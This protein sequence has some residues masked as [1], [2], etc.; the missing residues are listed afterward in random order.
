MPVTITLKTIPIGSQFVSAIADDDPADKND[1]KVRILTSATASGLT[2]D[3]I[4][5]SSGSIVVSLTGENS[6]WEATVRP[7]TTAG[8]V[9]FTVDADAFDEGNTETSQDIRV[10]TSFPDDDAETPTELFETT[11]TFTAIAVTPT[12]ILLGRR[13]NQIAFGVTEFQ[14]DGTEIRSLTAGGLNDL[15]TDPGVWGLDYINGDVLV[16]TEESSADVTRV[17]RYDGDLNLLFARGTSYAAVVHTRFGYTAVSGSTFNVLPYGSTLE[18]DGVE[19][20]VDAPNYNRLA[21]QND[22]LYLMSDSRMGL[23][24]IQDADTIEF[25]KALNINH[26]VGMPTDPI[27]VYD[28]SAYRDSLYFF[29]ARAHDRAVYTLD[30]RPYRPLAKNTKT[31]I[32]VQFANEGST[33]P[34]TQFCPDAHTIIFG[35]EFDKPDYLSINADNELEITSDAVTETTPILIKLTGINYIDSVE[36]EFYLVIQQATAPVWRDVDSL[37]MRADSTYDLFQIVDAESIA[38]ETG[39]TQP[40]GSSIANGIF[41]IGTTAGTAYFRATK[42]SLTTDKAIAIDVIQD[43]DPDN[44]SDIARYKIEIGGIDVSSDYNKNAPLQVTKSLD[45]VELT[46]YRAHSVTLS[47]K[48]TGEKYTPDLAGNFWETNNLNPGGY[49]E[50]IKVYRESWVNAAWV[51]SL[52]FIGIIQGQVERI[53]AVQVNITANDISVELERSFISDFGTLEKWDTLRQQSDEATFEG[54]YVP[55]AS[56]SPIQP[57]SGKA[58]SDRTAVTLRRLQIPTQGPP[59]SNTGYLTASDFRTSGGFLENRPV[60]NFKTLPRSEDVTFLLNQLAVTESVYNTD[61]Q[62]PEVVLDDPTLFNR[63]SVP[64]SVEKTRITRLPVDWVYD[65]TNDRVLILLSNPEGHVSDQLVQY[66]LNSD[67]F[68]TLYEFDKD[69]KVHRIERRNS[70]NYYI[71]TSTP[72]PQD[73]S[74]AT[75]PRHADGSGYAFDSRA[76]GSVI[77]VHH[78]N[79]STGTLTEHIAEDNAR[80]PQLGIHYH[81]GFE[82]DLYIDEFE[83]IR[84]DDRGTF[85]WH[86]GNLYYRY[87]TPSEFGVARVNASGTTSEMID[88]TTLNYQNHLNF[89]FDITSGGDIYFVYATGDAETSTLTLKRRTSG[90]TEST[91]FSETRAIGDFND[92]GLDWGAFLG[93]YEALFYNSN[94]YILAPIQ[95]VDF[96]DET[97]SIIN[98]DVDIEQLTAEKTGERN[99]TTS[100]NLNPTNLTLTPGDDIPLRI[101]FDG[102]VSG[103]TEDDL[104]V[105]GGT[106][107]SF[108]ISSDMI[109]VTIHPDSQ[110]HHKNIIIDVAEDAVDQTN[111]AWRIT[112]DFETTRSRTKAAGMAL[113]RCNV[114]DSNPSLTVIEHWEYATRGGCNLIIHD[115]AVHYME[116]PPALTHY[117]PINPDLDD[118]WQDADETETMG[119]NILPDPLGALKRVESDGSLTELGNLWY[120]DRPYSIAGTRPLSFD[121]ELHFTM[122]YGNPDAVLRYNS[123]AS[124]ADNFVHLVF[125]NTLKYIPPAFQP[126]GTVYSK[127]SELAR[128]VGATV[129][130][131]GKIISVV[132]RRSFRAEVDGATGTGTGDLD[133]DG[134]NKPFPS[135]GYLRI[136]DEFIGYTGISSGAFTGITRG[137]L[138]TEAV[139]HVDTAGILYVNALFS[140]RD[141]LEITPSTDTTRHHNIVRDSNN[142]FEVTADDTNIA[143]YRKQPYTLDLGL[144]RNEVAWI[145]TIYEEYLSEL[146]TLG[147]L[148]DLKLRARKQSY[149]LDLGQWIG[150]RFSDLTYVVRIE[151]ISDTANVIEIKGRSVETEL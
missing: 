33:I 63:G 107:E 96:G 131:D 36:F 129:S 138:G 98:P 69:I 88:Q 136:G 11:E 149:A 123:L 109:D 28:L 120:D 16:Q 17:R 102:T 93:A 145:E 121:G 140:E 56:L 80:P 38:F 122:G 32:P 35:L 85:K 110:T 103:A 24:E 113:Y 134:Q 1:F 67:S 104:T 70:T 126:T 47:L 26:R 139:D 91:I 111:E 21:H 97:Q 133:F 49:Q 79:A 82:N 54:V 77:R 46:R 74:A 151:M 89:A 13:I 23:A 147:K 5:L 50:E 57:K 130:F 92:I 127:L 143:Q 48:N 114:T 45:D 76:E 142:I 41:T 100:T 124:K 65:S 19:I 118:Y 7:P 60:L 58:W 15:Q 83:G 42:D 108:S 78:Y 94:L 61:I 40:T 6:V 132:D 106:I 27:S 43:P 14:H 66:N 125:G 53:S 99:V 18:S 112:I 128:Q 68:R 115:G 75:L 144:T 135:S 86:D 81:I 30:I 73:R 146:K 31:T 71:L 4:T 3:G 119:Y 55:E 59:L 84:P 52:L 44:F 62:L 37:T 34:L 64:F 29:R 137:A 2:E 51:E 39:E 117:K 20:D 116:H 90:G 87:A 10:S 95:K 22:L 150:L 141:L 12:R 72:I 105:Y 101:D 8:M 25:I 148:F 9:T